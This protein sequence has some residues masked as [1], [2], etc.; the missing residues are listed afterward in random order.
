MAVATDID[1]FSQVITHAT[2]PAFMLGAVAAFLS[3][4][5][6]RL[7]RVADNNKA[8]QTSGVERD[9]ADRLAAAYLRRMELLSRAILLAV[10][11]ALTTAALLIV[12]FLAALSGVGHGRI[13]ALMFTVALML[14]IAALVE[15]VLE[16][17]VYMAHMHL[18]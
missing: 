6:A 8:L 15:L 5:F 12:A 10:L 2:A 18:K 14:L 7:E 11:S 9:L 1:H 13:V 3:I 16:L 17:R 4:L